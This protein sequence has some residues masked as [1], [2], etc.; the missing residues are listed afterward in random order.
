VFR[1][2][3]DAFG[4]AKHGVGFRARGE[5]NAFQSHA[6][7]Y[8]PE[9]LPAVASETRGQNSWVNYGPYGAKNRTASPIDT[10]YAEQKTGIM[11][12]WTWLEGLLR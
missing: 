7:M 3:H 1:A 6:R 11:P 10:E 2:V 9:A 12:A 5:E 4:H 8:S